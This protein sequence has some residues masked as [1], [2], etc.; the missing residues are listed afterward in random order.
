MSK[1]FALSKY[2]SGIFQKYQPISKEAE[3][4]LFALLA[5][6]GFL[7]SVSSITIIARTPRK[8]NR[9]KA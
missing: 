8:E 4:L 9:K 7:T 6:I 2:S 5:K 1:I 3:V